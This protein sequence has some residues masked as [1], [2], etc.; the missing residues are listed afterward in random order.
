MADKNK[1]TS[2]DVDVIEE[3]TT[4]D[5][6]DMLNSNNIVVYN[7]DH[8]TFDHVINCFVSI[9]GHQV[10]QAEQCAYIIHTKGKCDV[11]HGSF[12]ELR[13][14]KNLLTEQGLSAVIE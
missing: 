13:P 10:T 8:N 9:L 1:I 11:K 12:E 2:I 4:D 7:D 5:L 6:Q 14:Y 3:I